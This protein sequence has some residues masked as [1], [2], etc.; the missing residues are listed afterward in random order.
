MPPKTNRAFTLVELLVSM[1]VL[2]L[3]LVLI[4]QLFNS[5]NAVTKMGNKHMDADAQ[6]RALLDRMA[7]DFSSMVRRSDVDYY[8]KGRPSSNSQTG[9]NDQIA[10]YSEVSGYS[11]GSPSPVSLVAYRLQKSSNRIER[12]GK[13][14]LWNAAS[15]TDVPVV[16]L[17]IPIASPL[18]SPLPSP[19]PST[20]PSPAWPQAANMDSD[21]DYETSGPQVFR[22]E[23][24]YVLKGQDVANPS[25]LSDTP[26]DTRLPMNHTSVNGLQD[27]AA[28]GVVIAVLDSQSRVLVTDTQLSTLAGQMNDFKNSMKPGDLE[29]QWQSAINASSLPRV[30]SSAIRIYGRYFY[31]DSPNP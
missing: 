30:T 3:L 23:Y 4:L 16:F 20:V 8:M 24:Y 31:L 15:N 18:P 25:I 1:A 10:F 12:L 13:G 11:T 5:A 7:I 21:P 29:S 9:G 19:M 2:T 27:V 22:F 17:P 6:A 26:W 28:I 14:L